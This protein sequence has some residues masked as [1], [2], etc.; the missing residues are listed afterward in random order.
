VNRSNM[1]TCHLIENIP[2]HSGNNRMFT[3]TKVA[4][5]LLLFMVLFISCHRDTADDCF[6]PVGATITDTRLCDSVSVVELY[7][8]VD[9]VLVAGNSASLSVECGKNIIDQITTKCDNGVLTIRNENTCNWVRSFNRRI[10]VYAT[11]PF[12]NEIR[13]ESSGDVSTQGQLNA[14]SLRLNIWGGAGSFVLDLKVT[15]LK[16]AMHYGT[17]DVTVSGQSLITTIFANSFGPFY[18]QNLLSHIVYIRN[19]GSNDCYVNARDIL[20]TEIASVG[21]IYYRGNP[22]EIKTNITGN[23]K[24]IKME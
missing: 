9:L 8:N 17:A 18:C 11:L 23:G 22:Y 10:T 1:Q 21:N 6:T 7:D 15:K 24:L 19:S 4:G 3:R 20:E 13:Y 14:D 5:G 12:L 2:E 16:L